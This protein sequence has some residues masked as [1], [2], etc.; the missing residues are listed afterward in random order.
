M[1]SGARGAGGRGHGYLLFNEF[2][3]SALDDGKVLDM[4]HGGGSGPNHGS[5]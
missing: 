4:D 1:G 3:V 2:R 5:V